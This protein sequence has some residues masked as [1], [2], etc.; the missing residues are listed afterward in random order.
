[1]LKDDGSRCCCML[2]IVAK[3]HFFIKRDHLNPVSQF[4]SVTKATVQQEI[5]M[6]KKKAKRRRKGMWRRKGRIKNSNPT[7]TK[8]NQPNK[9]TNKKQLT[10]NA[11]SKQLRQV[12]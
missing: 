10:E 5:N 8:T 7:D 11:L 9:Q 3:D 4:P 6:K 2:C 12:K 1:M